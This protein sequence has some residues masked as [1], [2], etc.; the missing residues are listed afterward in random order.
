MCFLERRSVMGGEVAK[1]GGQKSR[2]LGKVES[3]AASLT[4][5]GPEHLLGAGPP[6]LA[7]PPCLLLLLVLRLTKLRGKREEMLLVYFLLFF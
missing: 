2:T 4:A 7:A 5:A 1:R 3:R 6:G